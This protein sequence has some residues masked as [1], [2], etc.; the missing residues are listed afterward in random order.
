MGLK[1]Y[2]IRRVLFSIPVFFGVSIIIFSLLHAAGNPIDIMF[3]ENPGIWGSRGLE[4]IENIKRYYGLDKPVWYQYVMWLWRFMRFDLGTSLYGGTPLN[5]LVKAATMQTLK[6]QIASL[7]LAL[8][9][10][11]P[12]G[13]YTAL[14]QY[15]F[16]DNFVT[17]LSMVGIAI[18]HFWLGLLLILFFSFYL[19]WFP[20]FGTKTI[21]LQATGL[22]ALWDQI[23]HMVLPTIVLTVQFMVIFVRL[24]RSGMVEVLRQ[25]Y[26]LAAR[27]YGLSRRTVIFKHA[28]RCA[29][30][31]VV[32]YLGIYMGLSLVS[33]P[34]TETVFSWP[35]LGYL[36]YRSIVQLD[37][38]AVMGI[39]MTTT[40]IVLAGNLMTDILYG[41]VDPRIQLR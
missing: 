37:Y 11:I 39:A 20:S 41:V 16:F 30:I 6:L 10:A 15:S 27:S 4:V 17:S 25:D 12:V 13:V 8:G 31:P 24:T 34:V 19:P 29:L 22:A 5:L 18:P 9:I 2:V 40:I 38:P 14:K 35:G 7:T 21:G 3:A 1:T 33:A 36:F 28:L 23:Y 26:I 32:T